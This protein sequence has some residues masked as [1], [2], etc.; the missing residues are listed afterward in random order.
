MSNYRRNI[1]PEVMDEESE[2]RRPSNS[3]F[4]AKNYL[5]VKLADGENEKTLRIRLLPVD[6]NTDSPFKTIY[7]HQIKVSPELSKSGWKS[8]VCLKHTEDIDHDALGYDCPFCEMNKEAYEKKEEAKKNHD[9]IEEKR[10]KEISLQNRHQEVCVMR[11]IERGAE[12]D[13]PKFIKTNVRSDKKD[14]KSLIIELYKLKKQES[15][16]EAMEDNDGVL[17]KGFVPENILDLDTGRDLMLTISRVF[18]KEGKPTN[19]TSI[20]V[21]PYGKSKPVSKYDDELDEWLND[22]KVWS[23]VFVAKPYDYLSIILDGEVPFYDKTNGKWVSKGRVRDE[24]TKRQIAEENEASD[25]YRRAKEKALRRDREYEEEDEEEEERPRK[26][27]RDYD[28]D[29]YD[30][31]PRKRRRDDDDEDLPY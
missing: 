9:E 25:K 4:D 10:W 16:D 8:Y 5:N 12:D 29:D 27:R 11:C 24:E 28:D 30:E 6:K 3:K 20:S 23:D 15:I 7:M 21:A 22:D 14:L 1:T 13:G 17:P 2:R 26:K 19:K 18:D 31:R